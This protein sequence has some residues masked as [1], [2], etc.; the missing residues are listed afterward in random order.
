MDFKKQDSEPKPSETLQKIELFI[1]VGNHCLLAIVVFY[2]IW[3]VFQDNFSELT[4][5][6]SLLC[7]LGFFLMTE[8]ILLM[9]S[10]NAP[11][12]LSKSRANKQTLHWI[13]QALGVILMVSG[14]VVEYYF[15]QVNGKKHWDAKHALY[16]G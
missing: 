16:G 6:H 1:N 12:M 8:G 9:Y 4:C 2:L 11:T 13:F 7:T 5:V 14:S 10:Q 15:R 3:Y